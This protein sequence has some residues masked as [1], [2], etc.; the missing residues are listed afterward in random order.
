MKSL[1]WRYN[2]YSS[3]SYLRLENKR[4][5]NLKLQMKNWKMMLKG[6]QS[7]SKLNNPIQIWL[8]LKSNRTH[9]LI[10][11]LSLTINHSNHRLQV[12]IRKK[13]KAYLR[14]WAISNLTELTMLKLVLTKILVIK[15]SLNYVHNNMK[16]ILVNLKHVYL[17]LTILLMIIK[18]L[19]FLIKIKLLLSRQMV[20]IPK[21]PR[22][23]T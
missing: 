19:L 14:M 9:N 17:F 23:N 7:K 11:L 1:K 12:K 16:L 5:C 6:N 13:L 8:R 21:M 18:V 20:K 3:K 22:T 10:S 4:K 15:L 2:V